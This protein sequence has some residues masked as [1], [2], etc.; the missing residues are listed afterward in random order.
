ML[1]L[2]E[3]LLNKENGE[4]VQHDNLKV[5]AVASSESNQG[6]KLTPRHSKTVQYFLPSPLFHFEYANSARRPFLSM[7]AMDVCC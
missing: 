3:T 4:Q 7:S 1:I 6:E 2:L 5:V